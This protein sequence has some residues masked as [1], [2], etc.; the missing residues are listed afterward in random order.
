MTYNKANNQYFLF[1]RI[2][3]LL[4]IILFVMPMLVDN[5]LKMLVPYYTPRGGAV[6]VSKNLYDTLSYR[7]KFLY[8]LK[9]II[10][11]L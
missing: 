8:F 4:F 1:I 6:L 9:N 10:L 3:V 5:Y 7:D 11:C 2:F